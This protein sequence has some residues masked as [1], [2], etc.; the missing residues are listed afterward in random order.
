VLCDWL[1]SEYCGHHFC[2][3]CVTEEL[4]DAHSKRCPA[5]KQA[6]AEAAQVAASG[7]ALKKP[8]KRKAAVKT[9]SKRTRSKR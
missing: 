2:L 1:E 8:S 6:R 5:A 4:V 9:P 3:D 7:Q